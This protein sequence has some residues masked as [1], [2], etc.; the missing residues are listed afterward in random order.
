MSEGG[1]GTPALQH[2]WLCA[3]D[4]LAAS[5][6]ALAVP[7][8]RLGRRWA[9]QAD[10]P[11][12]PIRSP[13]HP[14][15]H[16]PG[17]G[18]VVAAVGAAVG[19][20]ATRREAAHHCSVVACD[21]KKSSRIARVWPGAVG[22]QCC[23]AEQAAAAAGCPVLAQSPCT[24]PAALL[25]LPRR[26]TVHIVSLA[27]MLQIQSVAQFVQINEGGQ[28]HI[29]K[30]LHMHRLVA[31]GPGHRAPHA[32]GG[33]VG[34]QEHPAGGGVGRACRRVWSACEAERHEA[35]KHANAISHSAAPN[36]PSPPSPLT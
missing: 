7:L 3:L 25:A 24:F 11:S 17:V 22:F 13:T 18:R 27:G 14:P 8:Q 32:V 21:V 29:A 1:Q 19:Q 36:H 33:A 20:A 28:R 31:V 34:Q 12:K 16:L 5:T 6:L 10:P 2:S 35:L 23:P 26:L 4:G 9:P 30:S 15:T